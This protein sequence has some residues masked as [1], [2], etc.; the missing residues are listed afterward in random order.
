[1]GHKSSLGKLKKKKNEIISN[2]FPDHK[3][4][5]LEIKYRGKNCKGHKHMELNTMLLNNQQIT[6]EI[7]KELKIYL[8]TNDNENMTTQNLWHAVKAVLR[9]KFIIIQG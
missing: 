1:M 5:R 7:R 8:K 3:A 4:I 6:K 9:G 2:I